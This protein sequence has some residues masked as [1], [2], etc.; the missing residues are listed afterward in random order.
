MRTGPLWA[1]KGNQNNALK[2]FLFLLSIVLVLVVVFF[3]GYWCQSV[4]ANPI[5]THHAT[6]APNLLACC[7]LL[8]DS[9][10][11]SIHPCIHPCICLFSSRQSKYSCGCVCINSFITHPSICFPPDDEREE[12]AYLAI[13]T[14]TITYCFF[15]VLATIDQCLF[16]IFQIQAF[17]LLPISD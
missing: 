3:C 7:E 15:L 6:P 17:T 12:C 16:I 4:T 13:F 9:S 1:R 11:F 10:R 2:I 14:T 8:P 5:V